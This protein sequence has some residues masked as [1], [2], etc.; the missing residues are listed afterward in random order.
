MRAAL[1]AKRPSGRAHHVWRV[2]MELD[3]RALIGAEPSSLIGWIL[4]PQS[5]VPLLHLQHRL[6]EVVVTKG[7]RALN[8]ALCALSVRHLLLRG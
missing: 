4:T 2:A 8:L 5:L 3:R 7:A 6:V 1:A